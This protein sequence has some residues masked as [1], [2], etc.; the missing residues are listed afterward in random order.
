MAAKP[1]IGDTDWGT[2][3]NAYLAVSL[4]AD[5]TPKASVFGFSAYTNLDS[6]GN[7]MLKSHAYK[8]A[9]DGFVKA[10]MTTN[11]INQSI[12]GY[13]GA[14]DDPEGAG[15]RVQTNFEALSAKGISI[16]FEVAKDEYFEITSSTTATIFWK[17][18]G[19][20][21]APVDQD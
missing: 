15:D 5:G 13:V 8:A 12:N 2:A 17:S 16:G 20:L 6:D 11:A 18:I 7:A 4:N 19:T 10:T 9:T 14:T 1:S 3:L 21:S